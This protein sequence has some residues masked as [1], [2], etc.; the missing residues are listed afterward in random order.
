MLLFSS[1][2]AQTN[3]SELIN[4]AILGQEVTI[5]RDGIPVAK[6]VPIEPPKEKIDLERMRA[7]TAKM[8]LYPG[9]FVEDMR[10]A[11]EL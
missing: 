11:G 10:A 7:L 2:Q 1:S 5:T 3:L 8:K 4:H 9:S 6:I